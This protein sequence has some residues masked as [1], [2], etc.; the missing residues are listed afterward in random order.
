MIDKLTCMETF[1]RL[2]D[3][4]DRELSEGECQLVQE[5]LKVCRICE[6]EFQF[7]AGIW[8][9]VRTK[10]QHV[11]V[12]TSLREKLSR[13]LNDTDCFESDKE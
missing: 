2:D 4:L 7:E 13:L 3:F 5:H 12:P 1:R 11:A 6:A 10:L 9:E 8:S